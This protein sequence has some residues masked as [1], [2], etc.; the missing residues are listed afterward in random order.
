MIDNLPEIITYS[1]MFVFLMIFVIRIAYA[2]GSISAHRMSLKAKEKA[3]DDF[4]DTTNKLSEVSEKVIQQC[5]KAHFEIKKASELAKKNNI[6]LIEV[7]NRTYRMVNVEQVSH[8]DEGQ[9]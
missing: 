6:V 3:I 9:S 2:L 7:D 5:A 4:V 8:Q 1:A